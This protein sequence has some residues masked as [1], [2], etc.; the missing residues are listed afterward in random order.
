MAFILII[1]GLFFTGIDIHMAT[2]ITYPVYEKS[3][4]LGSVI[5]TYITKYILN[6]HLTIDIFPDV[7][8][9]ILLLIG[10]SMLL[11][12][13]K[14]FIGGYF[15]ILST[16]VLSLAVRLLPFY[17]NGKVL[18]IAVLIAYA[19]LVISELYMEFLIIYV[20][21]DISDALA[22]QATNT[23]LKFG[24]WISVFCRIF[25]AFLTFVGHLNVMHYYL[26]VNIAA[27]VFYLYQMF[28]SREYVGRKYEGIVVKEDEEENEEFRDNNP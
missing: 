20:A 14:K 15:L 23:R 13:S 10:I 1:I 3:D 21:A 18:I 9:C 25:I 26:A 6:D 7:I 19:L 27:I 28:G 11:K 5:Q 8:G 24:W 4:K 2:S 12:H 22:N 17:L 16:A